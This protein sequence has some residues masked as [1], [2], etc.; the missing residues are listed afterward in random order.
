MNSNIFRALQIAALFALLLFAVSCGNQDGVNP[1]DRVTYD[2][3]PE[4]FFAEQTVVDFEERAG[5]GRHGCFE[6]VFPI[7]IDFPDGSSLDVASYEEFV[8]ALRTWKQENPDVDG[9]PLI[10][11][12]FEVISKHG[13][14]ITIESYEVLKHLKRKCMRP[15]QPGR[16]DCFTIV[17]PVTLVFP[18]STL[19]VADADEMKLALMDWR[20][21][22]PDSDEHPTFEFPIDIE[23]RNGEILTVD[24]EEAFHDLKIRCKRIGRPGMGDRPGDMDRPGEGGYGACFRIVFPATLVFPDGSTAEVSA[25]REIRHLIRDW[26]QSNPDSDEHPMFEFPLTVRLKDGSV[27]EVLDSAELEALKLE[28]R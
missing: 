25:E 28:C 6:I 12:P 14:V 22:N 8:E 21:N 20:E 24:S 3:D 19:E 26:I 18:E 1:T 27:Q 10:A 4:T 2:D 23:A 13:E 5:L 15:D 9:R 11:L 16:H 17:Y 7:T